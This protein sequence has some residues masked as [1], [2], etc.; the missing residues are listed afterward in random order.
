MNRLLKGIIRDSYYDNGVLKECQLEEYNQIS[1]SAGLL[2]PRY[3]NYDTRTKYRNAL[4]FYPTGQLKSIYLEKQQQINSPLGNLKGEL[5]TFYEEGSLHRV[6]PLYGQI[7]GYWTEAEELALAENT[8]FS[9]NSLEIDCK[10]SCFCFYPGGSLKSLSLYQNETLEADTI[11]GT[12]KVHLGISFYED[13]SIKSLEP[14]VPFKID[15]PGAGSCLAYNNN[16][17][18]V[19][20]DSNSLCLY[21]DGSIK[22]LITSMSLVQIVRE[23]KEQIISPELVTSQLDLECLEIAPIKAEFLDKSTI[24]I[25]DAYGK[26]YILDLRESEVFFERAHLR[27]EG[28]GLGN[29]KGCSGCK[30][31][32]KD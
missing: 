7:S 29:C 13:G 19:H 20:G 11:Y 17:L 3:E 27:A 18:G 31:V 14:F 2:V 9:V 25:T 16:P 21:P 26:E 30:P 4:A 5:V 10:V 8:K 32:Q 1:T 24:K 12:V 28:C 15:I 22:S 23:N 6:F